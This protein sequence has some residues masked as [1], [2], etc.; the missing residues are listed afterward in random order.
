MIW[1]ILQIHDDPKP[2]TRTE[3]F[4]LAVIDLMSTEWEVEIDTLN[5]FYIRAAQFQIKT[6]EHGGETFSVTIQKI[7]N[8]SDEVLKNK[9]G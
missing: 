1:K 5:S 8:T 4:A 3:Q 7:G 9:M 6:L 2:E